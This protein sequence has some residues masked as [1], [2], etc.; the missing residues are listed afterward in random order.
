MLIIDFNRSKDFIVSKEILI[1]L[2]F[3]FYFPKK[4]SEGNYDNEVFKSAQKH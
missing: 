3:L 1:I 2:M 4:W